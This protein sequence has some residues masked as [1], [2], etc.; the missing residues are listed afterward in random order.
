MSKLFLSLILH[1]HQPEGNFE[2]I[3]E[4]AYQNA[5]KPFLDF[6]IQ[7]PFFK[8]GLHY[9]GPL[10]RWLINYHPEFIENLR[11][12]LNRNQIE[13][14]GGGYGEPILSIW[15]KE[16]QL[17]QLNFMKELIIKN[18]NVEPYGLWLAER[19]WEPSLPSI[20]NEAGYKYTILDDN[21][22]QATG[23]ELNQLYGY[24]YSEDK[25]KKIIVL[26][27]S[28]KLR[29]LIPFALIERLIEYLRSVYS[30]NEVRLISMGDDGEKFGVWP[31][32]KKWVYE[33]KWLEKFAEELIKNEDWLTLILPH[34]YLLKY[35]PLGCVYFPTLSYFELMEW[36]LPAEAALEYRK[37][38]LSLKEFSQ[39]EMPSPFIRGGFWRNFFSKYKESNYMHKRLIWLCEIFHAS[40]AFFEREKKEQLLSY[41]YKAQCNDGYWHGVFSGLYAPHLRKAI[42]ENLLE[43]QKRIDEAILLKG[44][45]MN[46][47][48]YD[49][50]CDGNEEYAF[51]SP[52]IIIVFSK[53]D[54]CLLE[55]SYKPKNF[56]LTNVLARRF[57]AYHT[58]IEELTSD[59]PEKEVK[60]IHH[61]QRVKEENL[62][63]YLTYD[64][65]DRNNF[66]LHLLNGL[67]NFNSFKTGNNSYIAKTINSLYEE[68]I[69]RNN[70]GYLI[71][72][73]Q[74]FPE[75]LISVEKNFSIRKEGY[76]SCKTTILN[77]SKKALN[78]TGIL[79]LNLNFFI[80]NFNCCYYNFQES[81]KKL[82][83]WE[84]EV[85]SNRIKII[86]E[87]NNIELAMQPL[88]LLE[89]NG[90]W[91]I[92]PLYTVS[93]SEE[94][95][96]KVYQGS[97][98]SLVKFFS[99]NPNMQESFGLNLFIK[100]TLP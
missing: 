14:L 81:E 69:V 88:E 47:I 13:I 51:I 75:S 31:G 6:L 93:Q 26:P 7:A 2:N 25:G 89:G 100:E 98:I 83:D 60:T 61:I 72:Y 58:A 40:E 53:K 52:D 39:E 50:N 20:L 21:H 16:E 91:W 42:W 8:V 80:P 44:D 46:L 59:S 56:C 62:K 32:T 90:L 63:D 96:E 92:I 86:D 24:Y 87:T 64:N 79:E 95:Y 67:V 29:Y 4:Q 17:G 5:Y 99:L 3:I 78:F 66:L 28:N 84:G 55:I 23:L 35:P 18:F 76:I 12:L 48:P 97:S 70:E 43:V 94:G 22:F 1:H 34:E 57:E 85:F 27:S 33:E 71:E 49:F 10:L 77:K 36:A 54:A 15:S 65:Y 30:P 38:I 41:L 19:V 82:L 74:Y 45:E 9:S 11:F 73:K 68:E 37:L